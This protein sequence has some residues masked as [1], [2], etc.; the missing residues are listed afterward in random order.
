MIKNN[1]KKLIITS[2]IVLLP[3][4]FGVILWNKLPEKIPIHW[5]FAGEVDNYAGKGFVV[6]GI[7][8][9]MALVHWLCVL[10]MSFDPKNKNQSKKPMD[11]IIWS[12]PC[13]SLLLTFIV[14]SEALGYSVNVEA[15][16]FVFVGLLLFIIGNYLPK[17]KQNY[18]LGIKVVWALENEENWNATH[19]FAGKLWMIG[20]ILLVVCAFVPA[21]W[22]LILFLPLVFAMIII[23]VVY[24]YVYYKKHSAGDKE[25]K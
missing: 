18:T 9:L 3:I 19:R 24:S 5:N 17:C 15:A 11:I 2:V 16:A 21:P 10:G 8:P 7:P 22:K 23:P 20:S 1:V 6:F 25:E 12:L 4:I 13:V 14:Y